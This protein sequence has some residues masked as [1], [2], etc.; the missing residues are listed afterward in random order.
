MIFSDYIPQIIRP[1][2]VRKVQNLASFLEVDPN[3]LMAIMWF[4][5]KLSPSAVNP[6]N[7]KAT[8][9]IQFMPS[10]AID[11]GT[12]VEDLRK[13]NHVEQF[14]YVVRYF[15][16][17]KGKVKNS[18]DLYLAVFFPIAVGK[19]DGYVLETSK[20]RASTIARQNPVFDINKDSK[21]TVGE[22]RVAYIS[23]F[24]KSIQPFLTKQE[25]SKGNS[26]WLWVGG[27]VLLGTATSL[28]INHY[29]NN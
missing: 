8:G 28:V 16:R 20:T 3:W 14:D 11:L 4:E 25:H 1:Q 7:N 22:I 9:L 17:F 12:T 15:K 29:Q 10:T 2:F 27:A 23:S 18:F 26:L 5:S 19:E 13:M 24:P 21:I 6:I